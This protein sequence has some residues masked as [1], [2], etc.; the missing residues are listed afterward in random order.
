MI[1]IDPEL[2]ERTLGELRGCGNGQRECVV[3][4]LANLAEP[5]TV[6]DVVHPGHR[7]GRGW[8]D[9]DSDWLTTFFIG[10]ADTH[11]TAIAQIHT[12]PGA[13]IGHSGTDDGFVLVPS[14]GFVSIVVPDFAADLD[15]G[16]AG[17]YVVEP[18]GSFRPDP[19]AVP[20]VARL[21]ALSRTLDLLTEIAG[22]GSR[23]A[24]AAA[25]A[26]TRVRI[27]VQERDLARPEAQ[28]AVYLLSM[29]VVRSGMRVTAEFPSVATTVELPGLEGPDFGASLGSAIGRMFPGANLEREAAVL[30]LV[31]AIGA[32]AGRADIRMECRGSIGRVRRAGST[33]GWFPGSVLTAL[34]AAGLAA[35]EIHKEALRPIVRAEFA[36]LFEPLETSIA[37]PDLGVSTIDLG[38]VV[39]VSAGAIIQNLFLVLSAEPRVHGSF[40]VFD[41]DSTE[42]TNANRC[43][44]V[45]IDRLGVQKV[46]AIADQLPRRLKIEPL[47]LHLD[48]RSAVSVPRGSIV[49][50]GADDIAVR[51][52]AQRTAPE[53]LGIGATSHLMAMTSEHPA[54]RPCAGCTHSDLGDDPPVIPTMSLVSFW[55]GFLLALRL[56]R[57]AV[58]GG[59]PV[60]RP[61]TEF[62]PLR[63][64][65]VFETG[66]AFNPRCPIGHRNESTA[67]NA[68]EGARPQA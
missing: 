17:V 47:G 54:G 40:R 1:L 25:L 3:Y 2:V 5:G 9:V 16:R 18:D 62:Y 6:I 33:A 36:E 20:A 19:M 56:I 35:S 13:G 34:G 23:A 52:L 57:H 55:S 26:G 30:D 43:P 14:P 10:L 63:P 22:P 60:D 7:A 61:V 4:W 29:L 11:R 66:L 8:H 67:E 24:I 53:W 48:A 32:A 44:F 45:M 41:R 27:V 49:V 38:E 31:V 15:L 58:D 46:D 28:A 65:G 64:D 12:H 59:S 39:A 50:V 68:S 37:V 42:L 21:T 51:H